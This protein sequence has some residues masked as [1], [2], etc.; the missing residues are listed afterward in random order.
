MGQFSVAINI[1]ENAGC[2][3]RLL[4]P[5]LKQKPNQSLG[6]ENTSEFR[7]TLTTDNRQVPGETGGTPQTGMKH[8][9]K[10]RGKC[11]SSTRLRWG[12][13]PGRSY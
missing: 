6:C 8:V 13:Q 11:F 10:R 4:P 3:T 2:S 1:S 9:A 7:K 5:K 12:E